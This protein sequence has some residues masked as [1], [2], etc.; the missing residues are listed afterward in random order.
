MTANLPPDPIPGLP[1]RHVIEIENKKYEAL[2]RLANHTQEDGPRDYSFDGET[3][4]A[5]L[6]GAFTTA[7][8]SGKLISIGEE[9]SEGAEF[10]AFI[11]AIVKQVAD[12]DP[13]ERLTLVKTETQVVALR[14]TTVLACRASTIRDIEIKLES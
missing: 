10:E 5:T 13:G 14:E 8:D 6:I 1:S 3:W 9:L 2:K 7:R 11:L 4:H 12:L